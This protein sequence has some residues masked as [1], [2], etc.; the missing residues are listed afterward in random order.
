MLTDFQKRK[1]T[2]QFR[3]N[4][5]SGNGYME[6]ADFERYAVRICQ[7]LGL[8]PGTPQYQQVLNETVQSWDN[9]QLKVFDA[10]GDGRLSLEEHIASY[11]VSLNDPEMFQVL[12]MQYTQN[13]FGLWD[14]DRDGKLSIDEY[15]KLLWCYGGQDE[16]ARVAFRKLDRNGDGYLDVDE[17][18]KAVE[19]FYLSDD[20]D[21][22]GN[23]LL[24]PF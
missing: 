5:L 18:V 7:S 8:A 16:T 22:P 17:I 12:T 23:W 20:P 19:E 15:V 24:G 2:A 1:L 14:Q 3:L 4:D 9:E 13:I 10:D 11:D 21:A 6:R